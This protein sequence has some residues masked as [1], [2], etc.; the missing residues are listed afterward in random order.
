MLRQQIQELYVEQNQNLFQVAR[1]LRVPLKR[2]REIAQE[3]RWVWKSLQR[4]LDQNSGKDVVLFDLET[5]GLPLSS[6]TFN[7][8]YPYTNT[9]AY[10]SARI[11]QIAF[12]RY[13]L[14]SR[15]ERTQVHSGFRK[16]DGFA[17]PPESTDVHHL[18]TEFL[19]EH[20]QDF[21]SLVQ[22]L[23]SA[24][25]Q[26]DLIL[27]HNAK[28]DVNVLKSELFRMGMSSEKI[29][30][31]VAPTKVI[32]TCE[33]T[34]FTRLPTLHSWIPVV[35]REPLEFHNAQDDVLAMGQ[36]LHFLSVNK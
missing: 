25:E 22:P 18:T 13:S 24:L 33:L 30:R 11:L 35:F 14:G 17:V 9:H 15:L 31:I 34:D 10:D 3:E 8:F 2:I 23:L 12:C 27:A 16:P 19:V 5:T 6:G 28:F 26:C 7:G 36:I 1:S 20:G 21:A 4:F 29:E 32:C